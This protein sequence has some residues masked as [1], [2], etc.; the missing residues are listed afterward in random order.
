MTEGCT[1]LEPGC[2]DVVEEHV[3]LEVYPRR[4]FTRSLLY[5]ER[6]QADL[7]ASRRIQPDRIAK[8]EGRE[9]D[10]PRTITLFLSS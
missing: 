2:D 9:D 7:S 1:S 8:K 4:S 10:A 6:Q 5:R 3:C